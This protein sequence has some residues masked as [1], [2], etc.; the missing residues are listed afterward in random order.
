MSRLSA[1]ARA[2]G[3]IGA[4]AVTAACSLL[5]GVD[6]LSGGAGAKDAEAGGADASP[7]V[8]IVQG[9][10]GSA[11]ACVAPPPPG[12]IGPVALWEGAGSP[13]ACPSDYSAQILDG[14]AAPNAPPAQCTCTC[15]APTGVTC[16][17]PVTANVFSSSNCGGQRC[18]AVTLAVGSCVNV[19][20]GNC[21]NANGIEIAT[22]PQGGS[23]TPQSTST[24]PPLSWG[25]A[26]R[27]CEGQKPAEQGACSANEVCATL[28][29]APMGP[30]PCV[31]A[32]GDVACPGGPFQVKHLYFGGANDTR[33]CPACACAA[34]SG[35]ACAATLEVKCGS[36]MVVPLTPTC[37]VLGDP[38]NIL[39]KTAAVP[40]GG[41]CTPSAAAPTGALTPTQPTTVCC[42]P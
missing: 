26:A 32:Q 14:H 23:C 3:A 25:A 9:A 37:A 16:P 4:V 28:P 20:A 11:C 1:G 5:V 38:L 41:A 12:W 27:A 7:D 29:P 35:G 8:R 33:A 10:D 15:G 36:N 13:P 24:V 40:D 6:G 42:I 19:Q 2:V 17:A 39:L 21:L 22:A 34:P 30:R 18:D 31:L